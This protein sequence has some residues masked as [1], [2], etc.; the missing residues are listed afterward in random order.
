MSDKLAPD[1]ASLFKSTGPTSTKRKDNDHAD[2]RSLIPSLAIG[3]SMAAATA[4]ASAMSPKRTRL[5]ARELTRAD[6]SGE[7]FPKY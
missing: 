2:G 1:I 4:A 5:E 3:M 7:Y 6:R